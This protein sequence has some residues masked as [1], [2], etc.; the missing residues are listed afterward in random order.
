MTEAVNNNS[1]QQTEN[2]QS[3]IKE[4]AESLQRP[5]I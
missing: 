4:A 3:I 5:L 1:Y 2:S